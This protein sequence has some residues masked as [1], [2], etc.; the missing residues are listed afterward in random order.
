MQVGGGATWFAFCANL[1]RA[2]KK[3][4]GH[5]QKSKNQ[6][7]RSTM[8]Q[9]HTQGLQSRIRKQKNKDSFLAHQ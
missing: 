7:V 9:A 8:R 3:K 2:T 1:S 4:G 5:R 6:G